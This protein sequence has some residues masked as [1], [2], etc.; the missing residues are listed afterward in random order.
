MAYTYRTSS[1]LRFLEFLSAI[2][3]NVA[4]VASVC[5]QLLPSYHKHFL[6]QSCQKGPLHEQMR[7]CELWHWS[8]ELS[9]WFARFLRR[10][11]GTVHRPCRDLRKLLYER[12]DLLILPKKY[13]FH[14]LIEL[15][16][17]C[18][19]VQLGKQYLHCPR[20]QRFHHQPQRSHPLLQ[21]IPLLFETRHVL[22]SLANDQN[23]DHIV[24]RLEPHSQRLC[25]AHP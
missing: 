16:R 25:I 8:C 9:H 15:L 18:H 22:F 11:V 21:V 3:H 13:S 12:H 17:P 20:F 23:N 1:S 19:H 7:I 2:A 14:V 6:V 5:S 10:Y 24:L 4:R